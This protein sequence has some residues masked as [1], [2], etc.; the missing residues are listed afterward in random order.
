MA[1]TQQLLQWFEEHQRPFPWRT[2]KDPYRIWLSEIIMQQTRTEQ[3]LPYYLKFI[4]AFPTVQSLAEAEEDSVLKLWQGL[5]YYSRARNLHATASRIVNEYQGVFPKTFIELKNLKGVGDY[6]ASAIGSICFDLPEAVVDGNV[7]R[8]LARYF[9]IDTPIDH[10]AAHK[11]FKE[12]A[13]TL[14]D[15]SNPGRFNQALM[16]FGALQ[17]TPKNTRCETCPFQQTCHAF[18]H[19]AVQRFPVKRKKIKVTQRYFNYLV[20]DAKEGQTL[21]EQRTEKGIWRQ[22]YQFPLLESNGNSLTSKQIKENNFLAT[23]L[24]NQAYSVEKW[25]AEPILHKLSHQHLAITFWIIKTTYSPPN[26]IDRSQINRLPV[27]I[28]LEKFIEKY[29]TDKT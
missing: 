14:M 8:F 24:K 26:A 19:Q 7:Y 12:K 9:G 11:I 27:P 21:M 17:C 4:G 29:F 18:N 23:L 15:A 1:W 5:G 13:H 3:G 20:I 22:L 28:V 10:S 25:N 6:T 16:E 2:T